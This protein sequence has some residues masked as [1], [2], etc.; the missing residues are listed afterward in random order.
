M[1]VIQQLV[2]KG[3]YRY[4]LAFKCQERCVNLKILHPARMRYLK[5]VKLNT[6]SIQDG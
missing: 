2:L 4:S 5:L 3:H 1:L 6:P